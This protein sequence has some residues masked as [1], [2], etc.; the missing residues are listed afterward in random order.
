ME[1]VA[2]SQPTMPRRHNALGVH[3]LNCFVFTVPDLAPAEAFYRSFDSTRGA[4]A[5][6]LDLLHA[7]ASAPLG[8]RVP[9]TARRSDSST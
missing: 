2:S 3:S 4:T 8:Q 7:R 1:T 9:R 5:I 6:G